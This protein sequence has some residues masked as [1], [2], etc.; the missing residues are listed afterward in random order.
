MALVVMLI[1]AST[2]GCSSPQLASRS[3]SLASGTAQ[4][5]ING[6]AV[7]DS[8]AVKCTSI[9]TLAIITSGNDAAGF[10]TLVS[11]KPTLVADSVS[12]NGLGGFTGSYMNGLGGHADVAMAGNTYTV[13]GTAEGFNADNPAERIT[14]SFAIHVAC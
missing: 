14:N 9:G 6:R 2:V 11:N 5:T 3:G 10:Q 7:F 4:L 8:H 13:L 12:I 1:A